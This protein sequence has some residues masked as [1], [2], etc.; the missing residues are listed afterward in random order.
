MLET[1]VFI[2]AKLWI[3]LKVPIITFFVIGRL[4]Y[5]LYLYYK[6]FDRWWVGLIPF[7]RLYVERIGGGIPIPLI[8]GYVFSVLWFTS[9]YSIIAAVLWYVLNSVCK[10]ML[11]DVY[12]D[13][14]NKWVLSF[15]PFACYV[16]YIKTIIEE[17][18]AHKE[19]GS[20]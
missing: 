14:Y 16:V 18:L 6:C 1:F 3:F 7:G 11:F 13:T 12:E 15:I 19:G 9:S 2:I 20:Y 17:F 4:L 10:A 8:A 5:A